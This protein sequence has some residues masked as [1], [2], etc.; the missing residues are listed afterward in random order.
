MFTKVVL[1]APF[2]PMM[3]TTS[4]SFTATWMFA[5]ATT[6][7][8]VFSRPRASSSA[9]ISGL[10]LRDGRLA[11]HERPD[12]ARQEHDHQQERRAQHHLPGVGRVFEGV[13][14][15]ELEQ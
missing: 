5:A 6:D 2:A 7:P 11:L 13:G 9:A 15:H 8:K 1:P 3:P 10:L 4:C 12:A 14:A